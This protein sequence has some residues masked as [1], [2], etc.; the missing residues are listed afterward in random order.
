MEEIDNIIWH[1]GI[2][3]SLVFT[4]DRGNEHNITITCSIYPANGER[5]REKIEVAFEK[6][7]SISMN[8]DLQQLD[9]HK[10]F[11]NV[12]NGHLIRNRHKEWDFLLYLSEGF[13]QIT[14]ANARLIRKD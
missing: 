9:E 2:L 5:I 10:K 8:C 1:D 3:E 12:S 4:P 7:F 11:G 14:C 13:I 6:V